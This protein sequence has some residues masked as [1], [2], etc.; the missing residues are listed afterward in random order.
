MSQLELFPVYNLN[1]QWQGH[2]TEG[3]IMC[4]DLSFFSEL[5]SLVST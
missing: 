2:M 4:L 3:G 1:E 5:K